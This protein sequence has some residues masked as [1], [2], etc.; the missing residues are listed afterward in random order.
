MAVTDTSFMG[1]FEVHGR[2]FFMKPVISQHPL[3]EE[4]EFLQLSR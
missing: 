2:L 1:G 4:G 3:P